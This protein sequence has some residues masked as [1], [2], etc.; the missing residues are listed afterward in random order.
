[1]HRIQERNKKK[2]IKHL[3]KLVNPSPNRKLQ[4]LCQRIII[5]RHVYPI[6]L[7]LTNKT[8]MKESNVGF[9]LL[10][11]ARDFLRIFLNL[12]R[13]R[14][15]SINQL[16]MGSKDLFLSWKL[17]GKPFRRFWKRKKNRKSIK[18]RRLR[19]KWKSVNTM[20]KHPN[21][22]ILNFNNFKVRKKTKTS[23][24]PLMVLLNMFLHLYLSLIQMETRIVTRIRRWKIKNNLLIKCLEWE[25]CIKDNKLFLR[26]LYDNIMV[27]IFQI[28]QIKKQ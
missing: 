10:A 21:F 18:R 5:F 26:N 28:Y 15:I 1:M 11:P 19:S 17:R 8:L 24:W 23:F 16:T 9:P 7:Y 12:M 25:R 13:I 2:F 3:Q 20:K 14:K 4:L 22:V 6:K 27:F